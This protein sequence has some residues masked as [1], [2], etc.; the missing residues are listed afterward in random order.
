M[1]IREQHGVITRKANL[2]DLVEKEKARHEGLQVILKVHH[3]NFH[4]LFDQRMNAAP[5]IHIILKILFESFLNIFRIFDILAPDLNLFLHLIPMLLFF[6]IYKDG[7]SVLI[8]FFF[9]LVYA[10]LVSHRED[11]QA[12]AAMAGDG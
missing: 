5:S 4:Q 1:Q 3:F 8:Q 10:A 6:L 12:L 7:C 9:Q 2:K 11:L